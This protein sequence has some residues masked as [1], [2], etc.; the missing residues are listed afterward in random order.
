MGTKWIILAFMREYK[1]QGWPEQ[2]EGLLSSLHF[3]LKERPFDLNRP[4][5][6]LAKSGLLKNGPSVLI[7]LYP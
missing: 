6:A 1:M 5:P 2:S 4:Y 3:P 7:I